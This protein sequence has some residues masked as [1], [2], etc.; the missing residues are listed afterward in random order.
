MRA[1]VLAQVPHPDVSPTIACDEFPLI[2]MNSDVVDRMIVMVVALNTSGPGIPDL[3]STIL[4]ACHHPL[5]FAMKSNAS[6]IGRVALKGQ[7]VIRIAGTDIVE[8]D[9]L[10]SGCSEPTLIGGYA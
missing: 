6:D 1:L 4:G 3:D 8:F 2:R 9:V 10:V 5:A 7:D